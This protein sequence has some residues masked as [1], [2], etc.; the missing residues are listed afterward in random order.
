MEDWDFGTSDVGIY[1]TDTLLKLLAVLDD[2][3]RVNI[4]LV[5]S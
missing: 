4:T 5:F 2:D 1:S 3:I